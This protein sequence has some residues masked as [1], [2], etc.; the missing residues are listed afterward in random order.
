[1]FLPLLMI[2]IFGIIE[3]GGAWYAKQMLVNASREGAR[4]GVLFSTSGVTDA[5]V[6]VMVENILTNSS[7][8]GT[9]NVVSSGAAGTPGT[10]VQVDVTSQYTFPVLS[11]L[12][13]ISPDGVTLQAS[14]VMR[15]E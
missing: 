14:T 7:Y 5:D 12:V 9:V 10:L 11:S 13:G 15:H 2:L 3:L 6:E 1:M 4:Y 8:P